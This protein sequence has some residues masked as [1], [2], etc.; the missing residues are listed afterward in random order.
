MSQSGP[1]PPPPGAGA[2]KP[3]AFKKPISKRAYT[4][5][6]TFSML[7]TAVI[8]ALIGI[9]WVFM[10]GVIVGRGYN[11]DTKVHEITGRMLRGRQAPG[12]QEPPQAVLKPEELDFGLALRDR[13]LHNA[14]AAMRAP[15]AQTPARQT[16]DA[17]ARSGTEQ[18]VSGQ[19]VKPPTQL[20]PQDAS[21]A[22]YDYTYQVAVFREAEQADKLRERL[23]GE[24]VRT[25]M[26][27]SQTKDGRSLY[28]VLTALRGT[29]EDNTQ[30]LALLDRLKLGPPLLRSK[31]AVPGK[32][33]A[34]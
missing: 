8:V 23:E 18:P 7:L 25:T 6:L 21:S 15:A 16:N 20:V 29:E 3:D 11:P 26:E 22:R 31:K 17:A 2:R 12:V 19:T 24:G 28:K 9:S 33:G 27:K 1:S 5:N 14:T 30:L 10:L 32:T 13:P 4:L 34:R